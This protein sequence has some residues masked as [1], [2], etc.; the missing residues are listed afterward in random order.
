MRRSPAKE[1]SGAKA[2][3][4]K[5]RVELSHRDRALFL[6]IFESSVMLREQI[7][8]LFFSGSYDAAAKRLQKLLTHGYLRERKVDDRR[9]TYLPTWISLAEPA[10]S[11]LRAD[12]AIPD[13]MTW[14]SLRRR[15]SSAPSTLAHDLDVVDLW[16]AFVK[17]HRRARE[18][19][20]KHFSTWP[21]HFQ[22]ETVSTHGGASSLLL[23]DAHAVMAHTDDPKLAPIESTIFF[24]WDRSTEHR[25]ILRGKALGYDHFYR[26]GAYAERCGGRHTDIEDYPFRVVL[27]VKNEE[28]RNNL[29]EALARPEGTHP[30][31][32]DQFWS[33]TWEEIRSDPLGPIYLHVGDYVQATKGTIYDPARYVTRQRALDRDVLVRERA[34]KRRLVE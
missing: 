6:G 11:V 21:Y 13:E 17:A 33:T 14:Q 9:G 30:L 7:A 5:K 32:P 10:F 34:M 25:G 26:S 20:L 8:E 23:P 16:V 18:G 15:R 19:S 3:R 28:R 24:E 29:L 2:A 22:F 4:P 31:I 1:V 27:A 12:N